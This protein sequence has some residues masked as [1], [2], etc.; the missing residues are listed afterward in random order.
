MENIKIEE[1]NGP[2]IA[3]LE[4]DS[5]FRNIQPVLCSDCGNR[6]EFKNRVFIVY[7]LRDDES[8]SGLLSFHMRERYGIDGYITRTTRQKKYLQAAV[9]PKCGSTRVVFDIMI[10]VENRVSE[11][12]LDSSPPLRSKD[13]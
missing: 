5:K 13:K 7:G 11:L 6:R 3:E 2:Q 10:D 4:K 1:L 8:D 9:C 12:E